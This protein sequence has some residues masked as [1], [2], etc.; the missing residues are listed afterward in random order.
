MKSH[1]RAIL[2]K[3]A[4]PG[5]AGFDLYSVERL[6]LQPGQ[7]AVIK[8]GLKIAIPEGYYGRIAP[9]SGLAVKNGIDVM[10]GVIDS[11]YRGEIGVVLINLCP[12]PLRNAE[13]SIFGSRDGFTINPGD[14]IAQII[15][16]ECFI[17]HWV[18]AEELPESGRGEGG[19]SSTGT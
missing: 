14:R 3:Q 5:D 17:P 6:I 19:F 18:E 16:E 4:K 7:R 9:R 1:P 13:D 8:T 10:A 15:F 2:P 11:G 12:T